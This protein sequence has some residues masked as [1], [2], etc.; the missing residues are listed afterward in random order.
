[1]AALALVN[2]CDKPGDLFSIFL[3]ISELSFFGKARDKF[4]AISFSKISPNPLKAKP[5][6]INLQYFFFSIFLFILK[7][8]T[9]AP[10]LEIFCNKFAVK[11]IVYL[12]FMR[13]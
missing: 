11:Y 4:A 6:G 9:C 10:F 12:F 3:Y 1:M 5:L 7:G 2:I 13:S 8:I